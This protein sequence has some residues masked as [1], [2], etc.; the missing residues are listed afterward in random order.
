[1]RFFLAVLGVALIGGAFWLGW[2]SHRAPRESASASAEGTSIGLPDE[3]PNASAD[4]GPTDVYAHNLML[5]KGPSFRVYVRWLRGQLVRASKNEIPSFD[6]SDSFFIEIHDGVLRAN[7][8]DLANYLNSGGLGNSPLKNV[9][10]WGNGTQINLKGTL[11][12]VVPLPVQITGQLAI[13]TDNRIRLHVEKIDILKIPFKWLLNSLHVD[14]SDLMGS[15]KIPGVQISGNDLLL[16]PETLLPPPRIRGHLTK[17]H[18]VNPD[19]EEVYGSAQADL[20]RVEQWRNFLRLKGGSLDFGKLTMH[21]VDLTMID[22]SNDAWFDLD[23][24]HYEDQLVYGYTHMTPQAGLQIFMPDLD[25]IPRNVDTKKINLEW[26]KNRY[27]P[28]PQSVTRR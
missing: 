6:D 15:S 27:A 17:V 3:E 4:A 26:M 21:D 8:G 5:R 16:D 1:M 14:V 28:V 25:H 10:L 22:I 11:H 13:V 9:T 20:A 24:A 2:R 19:I 18:I 23:L 12:K 7:I